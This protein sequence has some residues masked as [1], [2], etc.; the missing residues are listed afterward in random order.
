MVIEPAEIAAE[1]RAQMA[2]YADTYRTTSRSAG[3]VGTA[4]PLA[5]IERGLAALQDAL[6]E[7]YWLEADVGVALL[8]QV[9]RN[10][11]CVIVAQDRYG[12]LLAYVPSQNE[13]TVLREYQQGKFGSFGV[14]GDAVGAFLSI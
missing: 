6:I 10:E 12:N 9:K 4:L 13:F 1:V 7:P 8:G 2:T 3:L 14:D 11:R 5:E